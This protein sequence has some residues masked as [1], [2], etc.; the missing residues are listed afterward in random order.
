MVLGRFLAGFGRLWPGVEDIRPEISA[1]KISA[2]RNTRKSDRNTN[3]RTGPNPRESPERIHPPGVEYLV[4]WSVLVSVG[5]VLELL[6]GFW[7]FWLVL[8]RS[9][10]VLV[11]QK[12][13]RSI[14]PRT[15]PNPRKTLGQP[16]RT[17]E[18]DNNSSTLGRPRLVS[19]SCRGLCVV[20][21][22]G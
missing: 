8:E 22:S 9:R 11:H 13:D 2:P 16:R 15:G 18:I 1:P 21:L 14:D 3:P 7:L 17:N 6:A 20:V 12:S 19:P 5:S 10:I 4:F